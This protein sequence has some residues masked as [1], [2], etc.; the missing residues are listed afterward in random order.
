MAITMNLYQVTDDVNVMG[1]TIPTPTSSHTITLKDGCS[2]DRPVVS[3]SA[4]ASALAPLNYA[5]IDTFQRYYWITDRKSL[6]NGV[7]ELTLESDPLESFKTQIGAQKATITRT[8][9]KALADAYIM[10]N[11]YMAK[12][13]KQIVTLDFPTMLTDFSFILMTVG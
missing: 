10:D 6:L 11:K 12:S 8:E 7:M 3:F 1:K 4:Q 9:N 2:I 5:Y 13:Y